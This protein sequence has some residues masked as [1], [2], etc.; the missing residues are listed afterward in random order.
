ETKYD[1]APGVWAS[2]SIDQKRH[3]KRSEHDALGRLV[4]VKEYT[5]TDAS[6]GLYA[7]TTY[8]YSVA[9]QLTA[10]TD[11]AGN[12]TSITYDTLGRKLSMSDP[13]MGAWSYAN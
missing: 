10:V 11:A 4:A 3:K 6:W 5:G 13:D 2:E 1:A 7:T 8:G 12:P 9:D